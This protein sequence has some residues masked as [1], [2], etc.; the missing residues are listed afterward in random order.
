MEDVTGLSSRNVPIP[1]ITL[2]RTELNVTSGSNITLRCT[3]DQPVTWQYPQMNSSLRISSNQYYQLGNSSKPYE[4]VLKLTQMVTLDT[5]FYTCVYSNTLFAEYKARI[6]IYV[7]DGV[8]LLVPLNK[9]SF[10]MASEGKNV[11]I[12]CRLTH[13]LAQAKLMKGMETVPLGLFTYDSKTGF[14]AFFIDSYFNGMFQCQAM[15]GDKR[16]D[17]MVIM[18]FK[19]ATRFPPKVSLTADH[20][21]AL[22]GETVKFSCV[23]QFQR[24]STIHFSWGCPSL[25]DNGNS[26]ISGITMK[27]NDE[28]IKVDEVTAVKVIEAA[29]KSDGRKHCCTASDRDRRKTIKELNL[30][31]HEK[32]YVNLTAENKK[33][34]VVPA[35]PVATLSA[36]ISAYPKP[37]LTWY[38]DGQPLRINGSARLKSEEGNLSISELQLSDAGRYTLAATNRDANATIDFILV[39]KVAPLVSVSGTSKVYSLHEKYTVVCTVSGI[40][41]PAVNWTWQPCNLTSCSLVE[42]NWKHVNES[43]NLPQVYEEGNTVNLTVEAAESGLF[44]CLAS[45]SEGTAQAVARFIVSDF[46]GILDVLQLTDDIIEGDDVMVT[47]KANIHSASASTLHWIYGNSSYSNETEQLFNRTGVAITFRENEY[48]VSSTLKL[49]NLQLYDKG[50]YICRCKRLDGDEILSFE[51]RLDISPIEVPTF[52]ASLDGSVQLFLGTRYVLRCLAS[53]RPVPKINWYKDGHLLNAVEDTAYRL[54]DDGS[55]LTLLSVNESDAG[56]YACEAVSRGGS[57]ISNLTLYV[58]NG[59]NADSSAAGLFG[60]TPMTKKVVIV[61]TVLGIA[62]TLI[63][64]VG[65]LGPRTC[66]QSRIIKL[67]RFPLLHTRLNAKYN[68]E[69]TINEQADMLSY[70]E[71]KW[72]FPKN[73]LKF[74]TLLGNGAFGCVYRAVASGLNGSEMTVVAVKMTRDDGNIDQ[75]KALA[76]ELKVLTH[77][78]SHINILNVLGAITS[79]LENGRLYIIMEY[80]R[81]GNLR[82]HLISSRQ[83]YIDSANDLLKDIDP[84]ETSDSSD[85]QAKLIDAS[86]EDQFFSNHLALTIKDLICFAFQVARGMEYLE[87]RKYIHRDLATRNILMADNN[88]VKICDFGLAK[89]CYMNGKY[90]KQSRTPVPVKWMALESLT[91]QIYT[92]K[93]DVWSYGVLLWELFTL[94]GNP[95]PTFEMDESFITRL[96]EGYRLEKPALADEKMYSYML[97]CWNSNPDCRPTFSHLV[98]CTGSLLE[99]SV[100]QHYIDLKSLTNEDSISYMRINDT[101]GLLESVDNAEVVNL[102][103]SEVSKDKEAVREAKPSLDSG[104]F[105]LPKTD[106]RPGNDVPDSPDWIHTMPTFHSDT[107]QHE[108]C[109]REGNVLKCHTLDN[110]SCLVQTF[111]PNTVKRNS[112]GSTSS[113]G[114]SSGFQSDTII[115]DNVTKTSNTQ[116]SQKASA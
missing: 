109:D 76:S 53:G 17:E 28:N 78:G 42:N 111:R 64:F 2:N 83:Y 12:P 19:E 88:V 23:A 34:D 68:P 60:D 105:T 46:G 91:H 113:S 9:P 95:Y 44:R 25:P 27:L 93:S 56:T 54:S 40:P 21:E 66:R 7:Y 116:A 71:N 75:L 39:V 3:G 18:T 36:S 103:I 16:T 45:N 110:Q 35:A 20:T 22:V 41:F 82:N 102:E 32:S 55:V 10:I 101:S 15:L 77:I 73:H 59:S 5:G 80:C 1:D 30:I 72:E 97:H 89:D 100:R 114:S 69:L 52:T 6:Y 29:D 8:K 92:S 50:I 112:K 4:S 67:R 26:S 98:D 65:F 37:V 47:C 115:E 90:L 104:F 13:P 107:N 87:S 85:H 108:G 81:Y 14:T 94:G 74:D 106:D 58:L 70:D 79:E 48:S 61:V 51:W 38:K 84:Q 62:L 86:N 33:V 99:A 24:G 49:T 57:I 11:T 63:C 96:K 31:V 43:R